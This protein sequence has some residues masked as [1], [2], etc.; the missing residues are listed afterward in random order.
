MNYLQQIMSR[1]M[2]SLSVILIAF[3]SVATS[4]TAQAK[5][6]VRYDHANAQYEEISTD[7]TVKVLG[8]EIRIKRRYR[9]G[10][11]VFNPQWQALNIERVTPDGVASG[12]IRYPIERIF[13][14]QFLYKKA[15]LLTSENDHIARFVYE[16]DSSKHI[17]QT[18]SGFIWADRTGEKIFYDEHGKARGYQNANNV[19]VTFN[20][21]GDGAIDGVHDHFGS[22]MVE[23]EH[24]NGQVSRIRDHT[25]RTVTYTWSNNTLEEVK[26][27]NG[28]DWRYEY[29]TKLGHP[30]LSKITDPENH[31]VVLTNAVSKGGLVDVSGKLPAFIVGNDSQ[32]NP[33][34]SLGS[35]EAEPMVMLTGMTYEDGQYFR[36][37]SF[38]NVKEELY[39]TVTKSSDGLEQQKTFAKDGKPAEILIAGKRL[40]SQIK[41]SNR[42]V[43]EDGLNNRTEIRYDQ[44]DNPVSIQYPDGSNESYSYH[45]TY[46][47]PIEHRDRRGYL[48]QYKYDQF[49]NLI[50]L[51]Q[52]V[53]H[54]EQR[55]INL[56]YDEY[57][58]LLKLA[59]AADTN[60]PSIVLH[61][62][63]D[64][65]GNVT[66]YLDANGT[67]WQFS[68]YTSDG[69]PKTVTDGR[70]NTWSY[71][72]LPSGLLTQVASPMGL[73][74]GY[75]WQYQYNKKGDLTAVVDPMNHRITMTYDLRSHVT[76]VSDALG[77]RESNQYFLDGRVQHSQDGEKNGKHYKYDRQ[78]RL[79]SVRDDMGNVTEYSYQGEERSA[80]SW[81]SKVRS[82]EMEMA[83]QYDS[84]G[85]PIKVMQNSM[86]N[87][88][89]LAH[90]LIYNKSTQPEVIQDPA[91]RLTKKEY[92][93]FG[94]V[95]KQI[96]ALGGE[97][98]I[99]YTNA[100]LVAS[101]ADPKK[102]TTRYEYDGQGNRIAEL[103]PMGQEFQ[104]ELD[105]NGNIVVF[106]NANG[107]V[108]YY[109][110]D[111]DNQLIKEAWFDRLG[112]RESPLK[113]SRV[114]TYHYYPNGK[115][116]TTNIT[117]SLGVKATEYVYN[118]R[119]EIIKEIV[120]FPTFNKELAYSY[121][122][123]G[124]VKTV[125]APDGNEANYQ[126]DRANRLSVATMKGYGSVVFSEYSGQLPKKMAYPGGVTRQQGYDG[127]SRLNKIDITDIKGKVIERIDYLHDAVG[128]ITSKA[129][130]AGNYQYTYDSLDRLT[131]VEQPKPLKNRT[132][133][134]DAVGNRLSSNDEAVWQYNQNHQLVQ[135]GSTYYRYDNNGN[136]VT[137]QQG[138]TDAPF[139]TVNH[140]NTNT[141]LTKVEQQ[142]T[143]VATYDYDAMGRRVSRTT[144]EGTQYFLY[145]HQGLIGEYDELGNLLSGYQYP[146][147][148]TWGT[149]PWYQKTTQGAGGGFYQNDH[150]GA[151]ISLSKNNGKTL[152]KGMYDAFGEVTET[153]ALTTSNL[154]F[155]GQWLD[156]K[157]GNHYNYFR[158]YAPNL[159]RYIQRD[160]IGLAG[161]LNT[162]QYVDQNP[163]MFS[164]PYGLYKWPGDVR[165]DA[166][167]HE[168]S[169]SGTNGP[170]NA[171]QHCF[172][173]C[174]MRVH[175]GTLPALILGD[176]LEIMQT[177]DPNSNQSSEACHMDL[178]N[179]TMG[180]LLGNKIDDRGSDA[181]I[182]EQCTKKCI[183]AD[184]LDLLETLTWS[185]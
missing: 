94:R 41:S 73:Q 177:L 35:I 95:T 50:R 164:D 29:T 106:T 81:L 48:T 102:S 86:D 30:Y 82:P 31:S 89:S 42:L 179:N 28:H 43:I 59:I 144:A 172:A 121:Y 88:D 77:V 58:Q 26:D 93:A 168:N 74:A 55:V 61:V 161:G 7:M 170:K 141:R 44:W 166:Y 159:G 133:S 68:N 36:Y 75:A 115:L 62:E 46:N 84:L 13:R 181:Q 90:Q 27:I 18:T 117:N 101:I 10:E 148:E 162:Y 128:N 137:E 145:N 146:P 147:G 157:T 126:Y 15:R 113:A 134:Y 109:D 167:N 57:G 2:T 158:D 23:I 54:P 1:K 153:T 119:G 19:N 183:A 123:N 140:Y 17:I 112:N 33:R 45:P 4:I 87:T 180:I 24:H 3:V 39:T 14:D 52:A 20:R 174:M 108:I 151:P 120:Q 9:D 163:L 96:D 21:N 80:L 63:Y 32:K 155:P 49:G 99:Q 185:D 103:L 76:S 139:K 47:F 51:T 129:T 160:P 69:L 130:Q 91:G 5:P 171:F 173:A 125:I 178:H 169:S 100:G 152:W 104:Y 176:G 25:D 78:L 40:F 56:E 110:Y 149:N 8:G 111:A 16:H 37:N 138:S 12:D 143:V 105:A 22:R 72:Y 6:A 85:Q 98:N 154:R 83:Y 127:F 70:K 65:Y 184:K 156:R 175:N 131:G 135:K 136:V 122:G 118:A 107:E 142:G 182:Y 165:D 116:K 64:T 38:Y 66:R 79:K 114:T 53:G 71:E 11:W 97:T 150:L 60:S 124:L 34:L 92:D 132:F 67:P